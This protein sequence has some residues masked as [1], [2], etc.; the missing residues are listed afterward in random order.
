MDA[1]KEFVSTH[2]KKIVWGC[3]LTIATFGAYM[4]FKAIK[5]LRD[6]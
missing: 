6:S 1:V 2:L 5:A 3:V 4:I